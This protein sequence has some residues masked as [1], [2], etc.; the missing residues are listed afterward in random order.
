MT[1]LFT[2]VLT[3]MRY[4]RR[5]EFQ[6]LCPSG[7]NYHACDSTR[8]LGCCTFDPCVASG[9]CNGD[10]LKPMSFDKALYPPPFKDQMCSTGAWYSCKYTSPPFMGC[11]K[12]NPCQTTLGCP[13]G[14]LVEASLSSNAYYAA[15][16]L[17]AATLDSATTTS[18]AAQASNSSAATSA[19]SGHKVS[20]G[21]I[22]GAAI[23]VAAL[24]IFLIAAL[25]LYRRRKAIAKG[26]TGNETKSFIEPPSTRT[27]TSPSE[28][29]AA[30]P[31][32]EA[33]GANVSPKSFRSSGYIG[34]LVMEN[35]SEGPVVLTRSLDSPYPSP[36]PARSY[37]VS[38]LETPVPRFSNVQNVSRPS[39][40]LPLLQGSSLH[41]RHDIRSTTSAD[42][43]G[44]SHAFKHS[45]D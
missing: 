28:V 34:N 14:D 29:D 25:C 2:F 18:S 15:P 31:V 26:S 38:E 20:G 9:S 44:I 30:S 33:P 45:S 11:C 5:Q 37:P 22:A 27:Y 32:H 35:R 3:M 13:D 6:P 12:S 21:A 40:E 7:G 36:T 17:S 19:S 41:H 16:W 43:L 24:V 1:S 10:A 23:G 4:S 42:G 39:P 8:F